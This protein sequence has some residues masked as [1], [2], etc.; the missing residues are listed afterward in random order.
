MPRY[1]TLRQAEQALPHVEKQIREALFIKAEFARAEK[2]MR[3]I[4][5]RVSES[6]GAFVNRE[7]V[8]KLKSIRSDSAAK[9]QQIVEDIHESG[10]LVKDLDI[11]LIDFP[12]LYKGAEVYLCWRLGEDRIEFW[13]E[14]EAGFPG[15]KAIDQEFLD[16]HSA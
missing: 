7:E 14:V 6:G 15:R 5:R 16:H 10:C 12:T 3:A 1:F 2:E 9:L 13:H 8:A 11:G 4:A